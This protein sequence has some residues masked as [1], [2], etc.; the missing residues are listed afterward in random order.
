MSSIAGG[1]NFK[2]L[3]ELIF[4]ENSLAIDILL[5]VSPTNTST[6]TKLVMFCCNG[7]LHI[8]RPKNHM[9]NI[10]NLQKSTWNVCVECS[11]WFDRLRGKIVGVVPNY[12]FSRPTFKIEKNFLRVSCVCSFNYWFDFHLRQNLIIDFPM[13]MFTYILGVESNSHN[14]RITLIEQFNNSEILEM[15]IT[16]KRNDSTSN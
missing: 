7:D 5:M 9:N 4:S 1:K 11:D 8:F 6:K 3:I 10:S 12:G 2:I 15:N 16:L 13:Q 14:L